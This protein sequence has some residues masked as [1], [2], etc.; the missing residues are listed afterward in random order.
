MLVVVGRRCCLR[1]AQSTTNHFL[2]SAPAITSLHFN[3]PLTLEISTTAIQHPSLKSQPSLCSTEDQ[4][5]V[6]F[7]SC[8]KWVCCASCAFAER[9]LV[10]A[11]FISQSSHLRSR[12]LGQFSGHFFGSLPPPLIL[13]PLSHVYL[14]KRR[15]LHPRWPPMVIALFYLPIFP[16]TFFVP[17]HQQIQMP[18]S[19]PILSRPTPAT[20]FTGSCLLQ[21]DG[22]PIPMV[23]WRRVAILGTGRCGRG[24]ATR[25]TEA[26]TTPPPPP[27]PHRHST[28]GGAAQLL[29]STNPKS[30]QP[31]K[32]TFESEKGKCTTNHIQY[33]TAPFGKVVTPH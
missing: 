18:L 6:C 2:H 19:H 31:R 15:P 33:S 12:L 26:H 25:A 11:R 7:L 14:N 16:L 22:R 5:D 3:S 23:W 32:L 17:N 20:L 27:P 28:C 9:Q 21:F 30:F 1:T 29:Y 10:R 4:F 8:S 13:I 24:D